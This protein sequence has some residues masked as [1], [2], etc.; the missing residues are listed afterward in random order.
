VG[1]REQQKPSAAETPLRSDA[2]RN[3]NEILAAAVRAFT[4]DANAPL[5]GIAKAAGV[6]IATFPTQ[7]SASS[8]RVPDFDALDALM[9]SDFGVATPPVAVLVPD[10]LAI[11]ENVE[12]GRAHV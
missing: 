1:T 12:I 11:L 6:R 3:K 4:K 5:E 9:A 2:Q 7:M 10:A 8:S